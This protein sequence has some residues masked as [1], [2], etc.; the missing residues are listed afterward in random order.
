VNPEAERLR[1]YMFDVSEEAW[2]AGWMTDLEYDLWSAVV[3]GPHEYGRLRITSEE[4][5]EL[6]KLAETCGGWI[7]FDD[8]AGETWVPLAEWK[9]RYRAKRAENF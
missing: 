2:C 3:A 4:V 7:V 9:E 6:R 8:A 1:D 5:N